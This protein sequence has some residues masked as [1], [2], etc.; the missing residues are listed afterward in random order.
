MDQDAGRQRACAEASP[1]EHKTHA[2]EQQERPKRP[3]G[4]FGVHEREGDAGGDG[5][6]DYGGQRPA[7]MAV[8]F[9]RERW[10]SGGFF[11]RPVEGSA[12]SGQKKTAEDSFFEEGRKGN[13][14]GEHKPGRGSVFEKLVDGRIAGPGKRNLVHHGQHKTDAGRTHEAPSKAQGSGQV[15]LQAG[16]EAFV[17][18]EGED[19][20]REPEC[21]EIKGGH[22]ANGVVNVVERFGGS[23][24]A[25]EMEVERR[26]GEKACAEQA[27]ESQYDQ[28][29]EMS[30]IGNARLRR[31][32]LRFR[33]GLKKGGFLRRRRFFRVDVF[34][35]I[36][37]EI[38]VHRRQNFF[39]FERVIPAWRVRI[40]IERIAL[41]KGAHARPVFLSPMPKDCPVAD[42]GG[43]RE[44]GWE[45]KSTGISL[46]FVFVS[47]ASIA[48]AAGSSIR[49]G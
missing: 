14:K 42:C 3:G 32:G 27:D 8:R 34:G 1:A 33:P 20:Q 4:L 37:R 40:C 6:E 31:Q 48:V 46:I 25:P 47:T 10:I 39:M 11:D 19:Q 15:P 29:R 12:E 24:N 2:D 26:A 45:G 17:P 5:A 18:D 13:T 44:A 41:G 16:E 28:N 35:N 49:R 30:K 9:Q 36:V 23:G 43:R 7:R 38:L 22:A 21:D